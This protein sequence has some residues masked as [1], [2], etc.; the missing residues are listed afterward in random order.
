M[1]ETTTKESLEVRMTSKKGYG[2]FANAFIPADTVIAA[3]DGPIYEAET[4]TELPPHCVD[5]AI[6]F[7]EHK[8]RESEGIA[9]LA[10]HSCDPNCGIKNLFQIVA[11]RDIQTGEEITW[12]YDMSENSDWTMQCACGAQQCR[13]LVCGY[14]FLPEAFRKRYQ[15]YIS[16]WLL[17]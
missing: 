15:G 5:Y 1:L 14:R 4:A 12:D 8:W 13:G 2:V 11:M 9:R 7:E 6:Q 10:N 3:F 17:V 16:E